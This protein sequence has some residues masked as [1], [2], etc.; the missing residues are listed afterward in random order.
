MIWLSLIS[1]KKHNEGMDLCKEPLLGIVSILLRSALIDRTPCIDL[2]ENDYSGNQL[3]PAIE[4]DKLDQIAA[5]VVHHGDGR[6]GN[7]GRRHAELC[8]CGLHAV[9][10]ALY[11]V[12]VE[13]DGRLALLEHRLLVGLSRRV[14]IG[15]ELQLDAARLLG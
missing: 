2:E 4:R 8:A 7:F 11:V 15:G 12:Y 10:L 5:G 3:L 13:H 14:V 1:M 6:A 9:V